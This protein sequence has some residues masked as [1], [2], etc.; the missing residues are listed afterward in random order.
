MGKQL[1]KQ[2][3]NICYFKPFQTILNHFV[4]PPP[5]PSKPL[6]LS[7]PPPFYGGALS[8]PK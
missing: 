7:A 5:N 1:G 4:L 6:F 2:W 8:S 3:G